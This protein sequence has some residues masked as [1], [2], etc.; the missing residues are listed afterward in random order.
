MAT[1]A[2][3]KDT[4]RNTVVPALQK[5]FNYKNAN[6]VPRIDKIVINMGLGEAVQNVKIIESA[7]QQLTIISGQKPVV[8]KARKSIANFKL[9]EN[10]AIG[11]MVT[12]R[13]DR[14]YEFLDRL[15]NIALARVKDFRGVS[16]KAFDGKGNYTLGIKEQIIFPEINFEMIEKIK[17]MNITFVTTARTD[18]EAR[19][20]LAKMGMPFRE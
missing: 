2:R 5:E 13:R 10:Q 8:T 16:P 19:A 3:L 7:V 14:M 9:R 4:Y 15:C 20:L 6:Q 1:T 17:G 18:E 12:L 11:A